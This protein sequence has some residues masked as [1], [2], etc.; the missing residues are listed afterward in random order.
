MHYIQRA[1]QFSFLFWPLAKKAK[2]ILITSHL[3]PDDDSI[4]SVLAMHFILQKKYPAKKIRLAYSSPVKKRWSGLKNFSLIKANQN[5]A[6]LA[7]QFDLIIFLD[8]NY[9][10][11]FTSQPGLLRRQKLTSICI[12]HHA[13]TA[14]NF[15]LA[16]IAPEASATVELIYYALVE[17]QKQIPPDLAKFLLLGLLGDTG[18]WGLISP[19][20]AGLLRIAERLVRAA[21]IT[22]EE[23]KVKYMS[24]GENEF[25]LLRFLLQKSRLVKIKNWP[26]FL[27][28]ALPR[29][30]AQK[31][32][33]NEI[34]SAAHWFVNSFVFNPGIKKIKWGLVFYPLTDGRVRVS[35]RSQLGWVNVRRIVEAMGIGSGHNY[36]SGGVFVPANKKTKLDVRGPWLAMRRWLSKHQ[37]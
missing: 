13:S 5:I 36:S 6:R 9:F 22:L 15:S 26:P 18:F 28:S 19:D 17:N 23:L 8:G 21:G 4:A 20:N 29:P 35:L 34:D 11:R 25:A 16:L 37:P 30:L 27:L 7:G 3:V 33:D 12:D 10:E 24:L 31:Y 2:S 1:K 32:N 14:D